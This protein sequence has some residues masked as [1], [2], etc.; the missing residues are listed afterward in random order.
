MQQ[1]PGVVA[2]RTVDPH[3]STGSGERHRLGGAACGTPRHAIMSAADWHLSTPL[4]MF[5]SSVEA[6]VVGVLGEGGKP[7]RAHSGMERAVPDVARSE[8][9]AIIEGR[10]K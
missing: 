9:D 2:L 7:R 4:L 8:V 1:F 10:R 3:G 5:F 6:Q